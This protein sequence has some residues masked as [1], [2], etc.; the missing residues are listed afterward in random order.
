MSIFQLQNLL[1]EKV[2]TVPVHAVKVYRGNRRIAPPLKLDTTWRSAI[3][4]MPRL[5]YQP[6]PP[7]PKRAHWKLSGPHSLSGRFW[8][9]EVS[10]SLPVFEA[11]TVQ[12][13][14]SL[15]TGRALPAF[16]YEWI[17]TQVRLDERHCLWGNN[18]SWAEP[19]LLAGSLPNVFLMFV[20]LCFQLPQRQHSAQLLL[21]RIRQS[22]LFWILHAH[23]T[24]AN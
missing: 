9:R 24:V 21:L 22:S 1:T 23:P 13:V 14:V 20:W 7:T 15:Y 11:W 10:V 12:P 18:W 16:A 4:F 3:K 5:L 2:K 6:P 19:F 8:R 17:Y